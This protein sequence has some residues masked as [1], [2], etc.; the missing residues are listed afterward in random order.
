M[1]R[2]TTGLL[3]VCVTGAFAFGAAPAGALAVTLRPGDILVNASSSVGP[4]GCCVASVIRVDPLNGSQTLVTSGGLMVYPAGIA[5]SQDQHILVSDPFASIGPAVLRVDPATGNQTVLS[6]GGSLAYP[7]GI[8]IDANGNVLVA[9]NEAGGG[10]G[11]VIRIDSSSGAQEVLFSFSGGFVHPR[12]IAVAPNGDI[13]LTGDVAATTL[14]RGAVLRVHHATG[15]QTIVSQGDLLSETMGVT[16]TA[17]GQILVAELQLAGD[18]G[19]PQGGRGAIVRIDP[20]SGAQSIVSS[21]VSSGGA[22]QGVLR[23]PRGLALDAGGKILVADDRGGCDVDPNGVC[24]NDSSHPLQ[25]V[26][27][28]DPTTGLQT[29]IASGQGL[30]GPTALIVVPPAPVPPTARCRN[31]KARADET[32]HADATIDA[33]SHGASGDQI[34]LSQSPAGPYPLGTTPVVLTVTDD[35]NS[36]SSS[37]PANVFVFDA[38]RP[39]I[40]EVSASPAILWP[41]NHKMVNVTVNYIA[42]DNCAPTPACV[43]AV[44]SSEPAQGP[45]W[46]IVDSH[47]VQLRSERSGSGTGRVYTIDVVCRD[48]ELGGNSASQAVTV[49]VPHDRGK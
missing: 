2:L 40:T 49:T 35:T 21:G 7:F 9:D 45:D 20:V 29:T 46:Q 13:F 10:S 8:A 28:I 4:Q 43:L 6:S 48:N 32:C 16:V 39:T 44:S 36:T 5:L 17:D 14:A 1:R 42:T 22:L 24:Q 3:A 47:H 26:V 23:Q 18:A 15:D 19:P 25:A 31:V 30:G 27:Q 11:A 37:C 12:G 34:S 38:T 41:P 33:G